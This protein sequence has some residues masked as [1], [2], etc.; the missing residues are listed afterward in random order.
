[1]VDI[2]PVLALARNPHGKVHRRGIG[3]LLGVFLCMSAQAGC[4]ESYF[5]EVE[6]SATAGGRPRF[7]WDGDDARELNVYLCRQ[8]CP[9]MGTMPS[10]HEQ[11]E[12]FN[13]RTDM[14]PVW[15]IVGLDGVESSQGG[16][17]SPV[18]YGV[19]GPAVDY[20]VGEASAPLATSWY[21]VRVVQARGSLFSASWGT[22][23]AEF[24]VP[25]P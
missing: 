16:I 15:R 12:P 4:Q 5:F 10:Y 18:T 22:A 14:E 2:R 21:L 1:M 17:P 8:G 24:D 3:R 20:Q 9:E 25:A 6:V 11:A 7:S 13:D 19:L 23:W